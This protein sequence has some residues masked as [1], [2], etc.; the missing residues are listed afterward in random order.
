MD[1]EMNLHQFGIDWQSDDG[2]LASFANHAVASFDGSAYIIRFY[3]VLPPTTPVAEL[4]MKDDKEKRIVGRHIVTL[5]IPQTN[6]S[7]ILSL[8]QGIE[9]RTRKLGE[10]SK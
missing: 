2:T 4:D 10:Q 7:D 9:E 6:M 5:A 8:L 1:S 3:Q